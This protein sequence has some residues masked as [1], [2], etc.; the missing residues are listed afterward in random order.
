MRQYLP[1]CQES[2]GSQL[3]TPPLAWQ[4]GIDARQ[5]AN[6][7]QGSLRLHTS[8]GEW[9]YGGQLKKKVFFTGGGKQCLLC[10]YEL[11]MKCRMVTL[12]IGRE[13]VVL[14]EWMVLK[15]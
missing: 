7:V 6:G 15:D 10:W 14:Q 12:L 5:G 2:W 9:G 11:S 13:V 8:I 1:G 4:V 3:P